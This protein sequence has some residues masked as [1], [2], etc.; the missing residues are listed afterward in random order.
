MPELCAT[1]HRQ[2]SA[3]VRHTTP[4]D[5]S[6]H[7]VQKGKVEN[8]P[9]ENLLPKNVGDPESILNMDALPRYH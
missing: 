4:S 2:M 8:L 3:V 9:V 6:F 7:I 1:R 5:T